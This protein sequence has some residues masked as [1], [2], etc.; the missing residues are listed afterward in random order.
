MML[1]QQRVVIENITPQLQCGAFFIKRVVGESF[2]VYADIIGDGHDIVQAELQYKHSS[3]KS[4]KTE[5]MEHLGDDVH[6]VSFKVLK[7]GYYV[8][9]VSAWV[10]HAQN[11]QHGIEAKLKDEQHV[12]S[13]LLDGVQYLETLLKKISAADKK[14]INNLI[15]S[16][17]NEDLYEKAIK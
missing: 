4:Y 13:E 6:R 1:R 12:N 16:F 14:Y 2:I 7:Q 5:R 10:D 9:R 17:Q 3:E 15:D 8:Y 11:W